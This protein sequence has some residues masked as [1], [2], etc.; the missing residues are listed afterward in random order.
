ML[1]GEVSSVRQ[2]VVIL[3][4]VCRLVLKH[5]DDL[6]IAR[7]QETSQERTDP[8]DPVVVG[9]GTGGDAR[10]ERAGRV[11]AAAGVRDAPVPRCR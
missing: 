5:L 9:E 2:A 1:L 6:V 7:S 3:A 10:S 8:V 11:D 4:R